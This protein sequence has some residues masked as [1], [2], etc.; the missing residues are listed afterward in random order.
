LSR[1]KIKGREDIS[2]NSGL[3]LPPRAD[4]GGEE[5]VGELN[6]NN[7]DEP[8]AIPGKSKEKEKG[9]IFRLGVACGCHRG[10]IKNRKEELNRTDVDEPSADPGGKAK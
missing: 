9:K 3:R 7:A 2:F 8:S 1:R 4:K 6:I 10:R 5:R